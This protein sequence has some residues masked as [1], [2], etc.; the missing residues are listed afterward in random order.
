MMKKEDDDVIRS[1]EDM[2]KL[3][4]DVPVFG[5]PNPEEESIQAGERE[6]YLDELRK[7]FPDLPV[8]DTQ[9][10][11]GIEKLTDYIIEL[12]NNGVS[13]VAIDEIMK[14]YGEHKGK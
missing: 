7:E 3:F 5:I 8:F 2:K 6:K 10:E 13:P 4:P 1:V 12:R 9:K 14:R 11:G